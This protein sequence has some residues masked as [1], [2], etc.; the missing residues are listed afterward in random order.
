MVFFHFKIL[1]FLFEIILL[2]SWYILKAIP[3]K[4]R[5][6]KTKKCKPSRFSKN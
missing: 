4:D 1:S 5:D 2:Y 3:N 6:E